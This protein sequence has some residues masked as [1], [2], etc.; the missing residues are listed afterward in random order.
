[1]R[2]LAPAGAVFR[3]TSSSVVTAFDSFKELTDVL[4]AVTELNRTPLVH[5]ISLGGRTAV[6]T[7]SP[8]RFIAEGEPGGGAGEHRFPAG[9]AETRS[10][11]KHAGGRVR[12]RGARARSTLASRDPS[13][14]GRFRHGLVPFL[15]VPPAVR[16]S[17]DR[18]VVYPKH[19]RRRR[20]PY[21]R[22]G[23]HS[24]VA[25]RGHDIYRRGYR[26]APSG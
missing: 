9:I 11:G 20:L 24:H 16:A 26:D 21:A 19:L 17:E 7:I 10:D 15:S 13:G 3:W 8:S 25:T 2:P 6:L 23:H 1:M 4:S 22:P 12:R 5:R 14:A 18:P